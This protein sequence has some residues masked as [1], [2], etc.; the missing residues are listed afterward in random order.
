[1]RKLALIGL[2]GAG[3]STFAR[4]ISDYT[5]IPVYHLDTYYWKQGMVECKP[6]EF[7]KVHEQLIMQE[8]WIIDGNCMITIRE[9][10]QA[11]DTI[12]YFDFPRLICLW[13]VVK[14]RF[15]TRLPK[16]SVNPLTGKL[17]W[18]IVWRFKKKYHILLLDLLVQAEAKGKKIY[19]VKSA[20]EVQALKYLI[21]IKK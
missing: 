1:M 12:I 6:E 11:A 9:R 3:K 8:Q 18:Y 7:K 19:I 5:H 21:T 20:Q 2:S 17:L 16:Q 15:S 13:R 10:I 14:R 4:W